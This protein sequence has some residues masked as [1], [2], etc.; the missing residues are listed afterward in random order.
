[1]AS[2]AFNQDAWSGT[3]SVRTVASGTNSESPGW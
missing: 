1:M 2:A 3:N